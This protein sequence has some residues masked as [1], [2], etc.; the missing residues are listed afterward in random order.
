MP[1][2]YIYGMQDNFIPEDILSKIEFPEIHH[3]LKLDNSGHMGFIEEKEKALRGI[4]KF[5]TEFYLEY[6]WKKLKN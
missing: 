6:L 2:L 3:I 4:V 1:F 5:I